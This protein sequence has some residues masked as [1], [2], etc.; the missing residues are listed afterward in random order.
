MAVKKRHQKTKIVCNTCKH[1]VNTKG[2][3]DMTI[4]VK[5]YIGGKAKM[6]RV[7]CH[8]CVKDGRRKP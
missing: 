6:I 5:H 1:P 3:E 4:A 8:A 2:H 7:A